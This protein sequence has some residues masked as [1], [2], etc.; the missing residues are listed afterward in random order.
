VTS[1]NGTTARAPRWHPRGLNNA[2]IMRATYY[3]VSY[4]PAWLTYGMGHTGTWIAYHLMRGGT[5]ALVANFG[6]MFPEMDQR[7]RR[8]LALRTYRSY[9]RD[10]IDFIRSLRMSAAEARRLVGRFDTASLEQAMADGRGAIML[11]GH[12]GN[13]EL[14]GV[15]LRR[16]TSYALSVVAHAEPSRSVTDL[17]REI[18]QALGIRTVEVRQQLETALDIRA[19]L[20]NNEVVAMLLDRHLGKDHVEVSFFGRPTRFLRTPAVLAAL[21]GAPIV[22]CFVYRDKDGVAVECGPLITVDRAGER[23]AAVRAAI[24]TVANLIEAQI[25]RHPD[26][27]YQFYPF[28]PA[29]AVAGATRV[30]VLE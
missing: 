18:R 22:P 28:W 30:P 6:V 19:R 11:S 29:D 23:D 20:Q 27:W 25:R 24:Q 7:A 9:A 15:L 12:F 16:L 14:G 13:W 21:S 10:V 1:A 26:Y 3:G 2:V 8:D 4:L 17:R 5:R